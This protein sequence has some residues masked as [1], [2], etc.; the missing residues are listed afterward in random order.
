MHIWYS[1]SHGHALAYE[2]QPQGREIKNCYRPFTIGLNIFYWIFLYLLLIGHKFSNLFRP[3]PHYSYIL[4]L[5][6]QCLGVEKKIFLKNAYSIY[7]VYGHTP[8]KEPC[9]RSHDFDNSGRPFL[10]YHYFI[11][12][13]FDLCLG[14]EKKTFTI[15]LLWPCQSTIT[16]AMGVMKF[17]CLPQ[18]YVSFRWGGVMKSLYPINLV[19][20]RTK[21]VKK[22]LTDEARWTTDEDG[23][24]SI[25]IVHFRD[26]D[27][28]EKG[29]ADQ[30]N[31]EK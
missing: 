23:R 31:V 8:E 19:K 24:Q 20:I 18:N 30:W 12:S 7:N 13:L 9:P 16:P 3:L 17:I 1:D 26:S 15:W 6:D 2:L 29:K 14:L 5:S 28:L 21:V 27:D 25:P 22:M 4:S 11:L 10:G